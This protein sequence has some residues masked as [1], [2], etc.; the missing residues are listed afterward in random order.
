MRRVDAIFGSER[1]VG[2]L[3]SVHL[4]YP[5]PDHHIAQTRARWSAL[6]RLR[7][8]PRTSCPEYASI[9]PR[10]SAASTCH[11]PRECAG[12]CL[13]LVLRQSQCV[14]S[15]AF[16]KASE[17]ELTSLPSLRCALSIPA[18]ELG[19]AARQLN[20]TPSP[21][22]PWRFLRLSKSSNTLASARDPCLFRCRE[23]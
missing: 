5:N 4:G 18:M 17:N 15:G 22:G 7:V 20:P 1:T 21:P 8:R 3:R 10:L 12:A 9:V 14:F 13:V 23:R 16:A 2:Q 11:R 19:D 6:P